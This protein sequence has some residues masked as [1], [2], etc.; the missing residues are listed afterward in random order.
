MKISNL[1][2]DKKLLQK[3]FPYGNDEF[4]SINPINNKLIK[5]YEYDSSDQLEV[6]LKKSQSYFHYWNEKGLDYR[7]DKMQNMANNV[8]PEYQNVHEFDI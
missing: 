3:L 8:V 4:I 7:L 6:K 2:K 5:R 1:I